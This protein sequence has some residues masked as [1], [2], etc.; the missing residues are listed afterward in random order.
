MKFKKTQNRIEKKKDTE[1]NKT[2][3]T[4]LFYLIFLCCYLI[5]NFYL[6]NV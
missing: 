2:K 1:K 6:I 3:I 5:L 4:L